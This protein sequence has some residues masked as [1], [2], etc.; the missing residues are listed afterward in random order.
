[1]KFLSGAS[2]VFAASFIAAIFLGSCGSKSSD[3]Q[4][5]RELFASV[6]QAA[7]SRDTSDVLEFVADDYSDAQGFDKSQLQT[8]L[9][10]YFLSHPKIEVLVN[11]ESLEFPAQGLAQARVSVRSVPLGELSTGDAV[12]L[13]VELRKPGGTW[14]VVRADRATR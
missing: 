11:I 3:E 2:R 9:R 10:G 1:M 6:E 14:R 13:D 8:F 7:E 12:T 4:Q 5:V